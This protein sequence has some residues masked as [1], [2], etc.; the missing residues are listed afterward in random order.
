VAIVIAVLDVGDSYSATAQL[1]LKDTLQEIPACPVEFL[2]PARPTLGGKGIILVGIHKGK[3]VTVVGMD[4][5][6][7]HYSL[8][9]NATVIHEAAASCVVAWESWLDG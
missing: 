5:E 7:I 3:R 9:E 4:D 6:E 8:D 1:K 2:K